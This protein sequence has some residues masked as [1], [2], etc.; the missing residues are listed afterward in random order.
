MLKPLIQHRRLI[1]DF[2]GTELKRRYAGTLLGPLWAI[3]PPTMTI[4]AFWFVFEI[5]LRVQGTGNIPFVF[6]FTVGILPWFLFIDTF[7][8]SVNTIVDNRH[9]ITKMV[10]PSEVLPVINFLVASVPHLV[11]LLGMCFVLAFANLLAIDHMLW[12]IY[13]YACTACVALGASWV[14]A[15]VCV[16]SRDAAP[17]ATLG[18]GLLFWVTPIMWRIDTL[19]GKWRWTFEWNPLTYLVDG[20]RFA[21]ING[22]QPSLESHAGF[23][24]FALTLWFFGSRVFKRLKHHFADVL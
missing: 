16:F 11:L 24:I 20:Y 13:F 5:G 14:A 23:W 8:T 15:S 1:A 21:L 10:F 17:A 6:Y 12:V 18:V 7:S 19:P 22:P 3:L 4:V 9:L 2:W